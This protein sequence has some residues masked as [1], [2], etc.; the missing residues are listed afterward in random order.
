MLPRLI[1]PTAWSGNRNADPL[2]RHFGVA[3]ISDGWAGYPRCENGKMSL[4]EDGQRPAIVPR[5][6]GRQQLR[7]L[8]CARLLRERCTVPGG[9]NQVCPL[10]AIPP[11]A[12]HSQME[13]GPP[14]T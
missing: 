13:V 7:R 10:A 8:H 2:W 14:G 6:E 4:I 1:R 11:S 3:S 12:S 5:D 9:S